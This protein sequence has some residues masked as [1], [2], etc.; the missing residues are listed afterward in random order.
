M[1]NTVNEGRYNK[2]LENED[3]YPDRAGWITSYQS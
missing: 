2:Q 1:I 3:I